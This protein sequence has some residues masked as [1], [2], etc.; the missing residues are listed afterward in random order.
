M[1]VDVTATKIARFRL[2][3]RMVEIIKIAIFCAEIEFR[4]VSNVRQNQAHNNVK[5]FFA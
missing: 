4:S 1:L 2:R 5:P 3:T